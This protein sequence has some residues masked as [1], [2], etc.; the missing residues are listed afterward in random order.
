VTR[1][2]L[3]L[4]V[5]LTAFGVVFALLPGRRQELRE[6]VTLSGVKMVLYPQADPNARWTF[7]A[8]EVVYN[9]NTQESLVKRPQNGK[10]WLRPKNGGPEQ[11]DLELKAKNL[12]IDAGDNLRT[13][14]ANIFV[15]NG[16]YYLKLGK[17]DATP[18]LIQQASGYQAP[19]VKMVSPT[20]NLTG[21]EFS[22]SFDF[23]VGRIKN[24][25]GNASDGEINTCDQ[26]QAFFTAS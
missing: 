17:P 5:L 14:E 9:P 6:E 12:T 2:S 25:K 13:Q 4:I 10:R 8:E 22:Y 3:V 19:Y 23:S 20:I 16:C 24:A 21:G 11:L 1:L 18:V 26:V 7:E 15:P